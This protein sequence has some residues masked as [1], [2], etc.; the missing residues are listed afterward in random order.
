[1]NSRRASLIGLLLLAST[2]FAAA[3]RLTRKTDNELRGRIRAALYVPDPLPALRPHSFGSFSPAPAVRAER[4][5]YATEYGLRVPAILYLPDPL[6]KQ[7]IP[8]LI[9]VDGHGGDKYTWYSFYSG[10]LYARAGA[11]VLTYD[12]IGEGERH[13]DHRDGTR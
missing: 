12:V 13:I 3:P 2:A 1:M 8:A 5:T 4:V 11:A 6:P 9:V 7:R 10:I